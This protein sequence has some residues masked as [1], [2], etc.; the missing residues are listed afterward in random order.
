MFFGNKRA[1]VSLVGGFVV[2]GVT[3]FSFWG[4]LKLKN[5]VFDGS[6]VEGTVEIPKR[7]ILIIQWRL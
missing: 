5:V 1:T 3:C 7:S 6:N 2:E 4:K